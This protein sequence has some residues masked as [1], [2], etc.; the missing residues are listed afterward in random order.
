MSK[1]GEQQVTTRASIPA[2]AEEQVKGNL[3]LA[4][5][6]ALRPWRPYDGARL[7]DANSP[8]AQR[9][10]MMLRSGDA[11]SEQQRSLAGDTLKTLV[12]AAANGSFAGQRLAD[13]NLQPYLDPYTDQVFDAGLK[14]LGHARD[15]ALATMRAGMAAQGADGG[16][17]TQ[18]AE[19]LTNQAM[20]DAAARMSANL[21]SSAFARATETANADL[22]RQQEAVRANQSA[23]LAA[24]NGLA[25]LAR[26]RD[27][28]WT[29]RALGL[30]ALAMRQ[31]AD[32]Q[33]ALDLAYAD[34]QSAR[35][36]PERGLALRSAALQGAPLPSTTT[37]SKRESGQDGLLGAFTQTLGQLLSYW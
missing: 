18:V 6:L 11:A 36:W 31:K 5:G 30:D 17:R 37:T 27:Q 15:Q 9:A 21:R 7:A 2:W 16:A 3:E 32:Q 34:W 14:D 4:N 26:D 28:A 35:D 1:G 33:A 24:A 29:S 23:A 20:L 25:G 19:A 8:D 10:A 22:S 12:G 13:V